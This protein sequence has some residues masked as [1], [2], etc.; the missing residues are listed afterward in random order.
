[1]HWKVIPKTQKKQPKPATGGLLGPHFGL[2]I[3]SFA[4]PDG[5]RVLVSARGI[6]E[7]LDVTY[8]VC[9]PEDRTRGILVHWLSPNVNLCGGWSLRNAWRNAQHAIPTEYA[10]RIREILYQ[11]ALARGESFA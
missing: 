9:A 11:E 10:D 4:V 8:V 5:Y 7:G 2:H 1:M 6:R 3:P